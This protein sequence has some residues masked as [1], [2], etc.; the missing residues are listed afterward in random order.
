V[1]TLT[2]ILFTVTVAGLDGVLYHA[3]CG[4][5]RT[6][7]VIFG[8]STHQPVCRSIT[9]AADLPSFILGCSATT[10]AWLYWQGQLR[11]QE[12]ADDLA[13]AGVLPAACDGLFRP[14]D[15]IEHRLDWVGASK[16]GRALILVLVLAGGYF[17]YRI[18]YHG[19]YFFRDYARGQHLQESAYKQIRDQWWANWA[20][21]R[22]LALAWISVGSAG[23]YNALRDLTA[24]VRRTLTVRRA[25]Q[26]PRWKWVS[27]SNRAGHPWSALMRPANLR[28]WGL[29][30]FLVTLA[31][32]IYLARAPQAGG[33]RNIGL[34]LLAVAVLA[35][36]GV[37]LRLYLKAVGDTYEGASTSAIDIA[38]N[39]LGEA[40]NFGEKTYYL[41]RRVEVSSGSTPPK[42]SAFAR[43]SKALVLMTA[44]VGFV[45]SVYQVLGV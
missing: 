9:L 4:P 33:A 18:T 12:M 44:L 16:L 29:V 17:F 15:G 32:L 37:P 27:S 34:A 36:T 10:A 22:L 31:V 28:V 13:Q 19:A 21:H 14:S 45:A 6:V 43:V 11:W 5:V 30:T 24:F 26:D 20:H 38:S 40:D 8:K 35:A 39:H 1:Y 2:P 41:L 3:H 25:R 7:E 23:V 42:L